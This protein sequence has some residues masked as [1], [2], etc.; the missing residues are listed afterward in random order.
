MR[1]NEAV[2]L[3]VTRTTDAGCGQQLAIPDLDI[4]R[5]LPLDTPVEIMIRPTH[6]PLRFTCGMNMMEGTIVVQ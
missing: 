3:V 5:D 6:G 2:I 1:A 4:R